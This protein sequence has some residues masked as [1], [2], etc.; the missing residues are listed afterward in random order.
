[1]I[2]VCQKFKKRE[3]TKAL[4]FNT[5][6]NLTTDSYLF[7]ESRKNKFDYKFITAVTTTGIFCLPSCRAKKPNRENVIFFD[8]NKEAIM[9]G[10]RA[11]KICKP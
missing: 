3:K 4:L 1:M 9:N 11:C 2:Q 5:P 8:I 10:F 6:E 7:I